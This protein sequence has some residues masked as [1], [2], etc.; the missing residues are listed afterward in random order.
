LYN[1]Y[2][3]ETVNAKSDAIYAM[4]LDFKNRNVPLDGIG[5]PVAH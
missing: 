3:A 1:D 2:S 4:A 5:F